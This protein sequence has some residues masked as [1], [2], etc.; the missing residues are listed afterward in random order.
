[1]TAGS[2]RLSYVAGRTS[3]EI[4]TSMGMAQSTVKWR[5]SRSKERLREEMAPYG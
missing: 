2:F 5:L 4:G 3:A 1:M